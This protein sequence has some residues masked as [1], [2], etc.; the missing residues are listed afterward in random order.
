[1]VQCIMKQVNPVFGRNR[2]KIHINSLIP[3]FLDTNNNIISFRS[4]TKSRGVVDL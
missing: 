1:M 4:R 3:A 2:K